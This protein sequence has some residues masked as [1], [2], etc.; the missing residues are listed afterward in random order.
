[1]LTY[2]VDM[3]HMKNANIDSLEPVKDAIGKTDLWKNLPQEKLTT[4]T[5]AKTI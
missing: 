2:S 1:M 5:R 4:I 3:E